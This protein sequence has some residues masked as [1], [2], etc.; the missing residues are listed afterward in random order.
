MK[1]ILLQVVN[2]TSTKIRKYVAGKKSFIVLFLFCSLL[3]KQQLIAQVV[4]NGNFENTNPDGS[5]CNWGN[6]YIFAVWS[7]SNG[8]FHNDSIVRDGAFYEATPNAY[9]GTKALRLAN[10][11]NFSTNTGIAGAVAA[12]DDSVFSSWGILN[13]VP[14]NSTA[15]SPFQPDNFGFNYIYSAINGDTAMAQLALWDSSGNVVAT[16]TIFITDSSNV[17]QQIS[18]PIYYTSTGS[19]AFYSLSIHNF[20]T[21]SQSV[22]QPSFGTRLLVD[23]VGFNV[24]NATSIEEKAAK[25]NFNIAPNPGNSYI[26]ITNPPDQEYELILIDGQG[27]ICLNQKNTTWLN[28]QNYPDGMYTVQL[29][30]SQS[31]TSKK[32]IK[33]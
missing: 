3:F 19:A 15:L 24:V 13:L 14:T 8:V 18:A 11:W 6:V 16:G 5:L 30:T 33:Q 31:L 25:P 7:D 9:S 28:L 22:R 21:A 20:Y 12:D 29:K 4:P 27:K 2:G 1:T 17:Y 23:N 10:A 26:K 32:F